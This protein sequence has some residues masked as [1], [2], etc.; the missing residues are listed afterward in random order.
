MDNQGARH[1]SISVRHNKLEFGTCRSRCWY[2]RRA[3]KICIDWQEVKHDFDFYL[4]NI[5]ESMRDIKLEKPDSTVKHETKSWKTFI[6]YIRN[7]YICG[8]NSLT[9]KHPYISVE[10]ILTQIAHYQLINRILMRTK[11]NLKEKLNDNFKQFV[12]SPTNSA[13][14]KDCINADKR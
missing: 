2:Y 7:S 8:Y 10:H 11:L 1:K 13:W 14:S 12:K 3:S 6:E 4:Q 9:L 5:Y